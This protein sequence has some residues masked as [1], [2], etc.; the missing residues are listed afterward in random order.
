MD[1]RIDM[2]SAQAISAAFAHAPEMVLDELATTMGTVTEYLRRETGEVMAERGVNASG[3]LRDSF[4]PRVDVISQ[5]D[6][7]FGSVTSALPYA[8]PVELG[9]K[10]HT[11][12]IEPLI[13]WVEL[14]LDLYGDEAE[15]RA[16]A[17]QRS[18]ARRGTLG[19]G[20][21]HQALADGRSTIQA[22]F[23]ECALRIQG[24]IASAAG[25]KS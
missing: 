3:L 24:R 13:N 8:L 18:I 17:I 7:V 2:P 19:R 21:A 12:P 16:R 20:M 14:K 5:L 6:A 23:E 1:I 15:A 22:D 25:G 11:P 10:P 9:T 4:I